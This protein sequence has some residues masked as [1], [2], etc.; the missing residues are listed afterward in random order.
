[1]KPR[2]L[3]VARTRYELPLSPSLERKFDALRERFDVRVLATSADGRARDDGTFRLVGRLPLFDG[4]LFYALLPF[5]VRRLAREHRPAAIV[6]QSP[7]EAALVRARAHG[8]A[9]RRRGARRLAHGD[10][11]LRLAASARALAARRRRRHLWAPPR[12]RGADDLAVHVRARPRA[13]RRARA[14]FADVHRPRACSPSGRR[15]RCRRRPRRSSSACSSSTRTSTGSRARGASRRR[16]LP[17]AQLRLVGRGSRSAVVEQLVRDLPAQTTWTERL[18]PAEVAR[19]MDEATCLVLPSRSEGLGRVLIEAFLRGRPAVAMDVGGIRD[20][21]EDG[22]SGL[23]VDLGRGARR[24]TRP[25]ALRPAARR[26]ARRRR[27][28]QRRSVAGRRPRSTRSASP[29]SSGNTL[30]REMTAQQAK[31]VVKNALYRTIGETSTAL[32]LAPERAD[33][34]CACSC[35]TR[36]TTSRTTRRRCRSRVFDEQLAQARRARLQR[37]RPRRRARPLHRS[38]SRC[39]RRRC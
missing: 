5:R 23:L 36:S 31:Q 16:A 11:A 1:M 21:V 32:R 7:Y 25:R 4:P 29:R 30:E 26:A 15:C 6:T 28:P 19:A 18:S 3:L 34:R 22:V 9:G 8:R 39:P 13:R 24:R 10:A 12:R 37:R 2:L 17:G 20:V 35:T 33:A 14:E 27:T 38:A